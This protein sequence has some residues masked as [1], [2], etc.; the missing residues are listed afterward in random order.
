MKR[1]GG[2]TL[3]AALLII[4]LTSSV[5]KA[6]TL[7]VIQADDSFDF[8]SGIG[9]DRTGNVYVADSHNNAIYKVSPSAIV[10]IFAGTA[11]TWGNVDGTGSAARFDE[12]HAITTDGAGNV[13]VADSR[14][15]AVRKITPAGVVTTLGG[16]LGTWPAGVAIDGVGN[17][18]VAGIADN[19][20]RKITPT[21]V[22][23][24]LAGTAGVS[25][26]A[27]GTGKAASFNLPASVAIDSMG[28]LFVAESGNNTIRKITPTGAVTTLAGTA[29][30]KGAANGTGAAARFNHP[31]GVTTDSAGNIYVADSGNNTIRKI[32]PAGLVT[33]LAGT[34]EKEGDS[35]GTG[36]SARFFQPNGVAT[37][38]AGNVYVADTCNHAIRKITPEG[39]VTTWM[40]NKGDLSCEEAGAD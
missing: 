30:K 28:N 18:Y 16:D 13:Y 20:I 40:K 38:S 37:D 12:P 34:A 15:N 31:M 3:T 21:G 39:V 8:P 2:R 10:T 27:D 1:I 29:G 6:G 33:T 4:L 11:G 9:V 17:V 25:G 35:D 24:T 23:T 19:I 36:A 26:H 32:T 5:S 14:N 22:A 7:D